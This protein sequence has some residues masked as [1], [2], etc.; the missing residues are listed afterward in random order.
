MTQNGVHTAPSLLD[1][2][3]KTPGVSR[4]KQMY[5][6]FKKNREERPE[7]PEARE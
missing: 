5:A 4:V 1:N 2:Y 7:E 6:R 3:T